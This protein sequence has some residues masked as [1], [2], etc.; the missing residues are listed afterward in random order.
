M[1]CDVLQYNCCVA[2]E[3]TVA[4]CIVD[5]HVVFCVNMSSCVVCLLINCC[6]IYSIDY[7]TM[8]LCNL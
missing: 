2:E 7:S 8:L 6:I 4:L 5:C 1:C 3:L